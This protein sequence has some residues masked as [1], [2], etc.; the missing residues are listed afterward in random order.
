[1][2]SKK[3]E[4]SLKELLKVNNDEIKK[5]YCSYSLLG[6]FRFVRLDFKEDM[7]PP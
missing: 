2:E 3:F 1:M 4:E 7:T 6:I 5:I